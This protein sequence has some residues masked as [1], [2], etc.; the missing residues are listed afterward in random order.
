ML[1]IKLPFQL[2]H[3]LGFNPHKIKMFEKKPIWKW[4]IL[5][6]QICLKMSPKLSYVESWTSPWN[7]LETSRL[8]FFFNIFGSVINQGFLTMTPFIWAML[9]LENY[10]D[11]FFKNPPSWITSLVIGAQTEQNNV[12]TIS[13]NVHDYIKVVLEKKIVYK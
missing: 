2:Y 13:D 3:H 12:F 5:S 4:S 10:K 6:L 9:W 11:F 1:Y 7:Y 8:L